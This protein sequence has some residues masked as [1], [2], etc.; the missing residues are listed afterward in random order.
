GRGGNGGSGA[1]GARGGEGAAGGPAGA[2]G[3]GAG[4]TIRLVASVLDARALTVDAGGGAGGNAT[5]GGGAG[6]FLFNSNTNVNTADWH[7]TAQ[8]AS[9]VKLLG[10]NPFVTGSPA[11]P[12]LPDLVGGAYDFGLVPGAAGARQAVAQA[13]GAVAALIRTHRTFAGD[14][15]PGFDQLMLVNLTT[16]TTLGNPMLGAGDRTHLQV[17][18]QDGLANDP[19]YG[20]NNPIPITQLA[21]GQAYVTLIPVNTTGFNLEATFGGQTFRASSPALAD[22]Q[23]MYLTRAQVAGLTGADI[24][25]DGSTDLLAVGPDGALTTW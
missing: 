18:L 24:D 12:L 20:Q 17:L 4:G 6:R 5:N 9:S 15:F 13:P 3:G 2:G 16:D 23:V 25:H 1:M 21:P 14:D 8:Q 7:V 19:S 22:G 11:V 10:A